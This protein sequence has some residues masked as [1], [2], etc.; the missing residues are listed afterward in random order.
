MIALLREW[1]RAG[2]VVWLAVTVFSLLVTVAV[3]SFGLSHSAE[4]SQLLRVVFLIRN[5]ALEPAS[6]KAM[7]EGAARGVVGA[8][9]DPY[10]S[11]LDPQQY[12][13]LAQQIS[14]SYGGVGLVIGLDEEG[15]L[16]VIT[17]FKGAPAHRAGIQSGDL[18]IRIEGR[19]TRSLGLEEAAALLQGKPGTAVVLAVQR[20]GNGIR[21]YRI[22]RE[23][24]VI[25]SVEGRRLPGHPEFGYV[26]ITTFSEQ[27][28]KA[29]ERTLAEIGA[30][31]L[32]G[33]ILDLRNN[34][35]GELGAAV[36]VAGRFVP[37]GPVVYTVSRRQTVPY[38]AQGP[39]L[40]VPL[41]V[42]INGGTA[43]A[44]EI[45]AGAIKDTGS[46]ILVGERTFGKG[47]VQKVFL[48]D[49]GAA[50]K[51]TT[52][53]YLTP[54]KRDINGQGIEPDVLVAL[55]PE[56][57]ARVLLKAPDLV[58]DRQLQKAVEL[59]QRSGKS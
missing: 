49:S 45:V 56:V 21:E 26:N 33:I 54:A 22:T 42:L 57:T 9:E 25:P 13:H 53:K 11:Y 36:A 44:A 47:R 39:K 32:R 14:G 7:L 16:K 6:T 48:L 40:D 59:L 8:L 28:P 19:D 2:K 4:V 46:G 5:E 35:G 58:H 51:L 10:S 20:P 37:P 55:S 27:T 23:E 1:R 24:I 15:R 52:E 34:P 38:L 17:P 31:D 3:L 50:L 30:S 43:S 29:L 18:I 41:V 12:R